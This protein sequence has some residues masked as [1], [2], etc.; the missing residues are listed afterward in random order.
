MKKLRILVL[1]HED[2]VPP[3]SLDGYTDKEIIEWKTEYDVVSTLRDMG[4]EVIPLGVHDDLGSIR[5]TFRDSRPHIA[6]NL[7]EEFHGNSL[8][9]YH[10]ASYM[11]LLRLHYT[12]CNPRGLMLAHDKSLCKKLLAF[13][14]INT[15]RFATFPLGRK[16]RCPKRLRFP[17]IVKSLVEEGSYGLAQASVVNTEEKLLER[18]QYLHE[19]LETPVIAEEYIDG[20]E[21][22][23]AV[24]GNLRLQVLPVLELKFGDLPEGTH[25]FATT[26]V[27]WDWNYQDE[28][29]IEV[30]VA[31]DIPAG[32]MTELTRLGKRIYKVL[33]MSGYARID[34]R[35]T[36]N[37]RLYVL[38]ANANP[39]IGYG[40][41][42]S[43]AAEAAG[44]SYEQLLQKVINLGLAYKSGM[45]R[46]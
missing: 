1:M 34:L 27:K 31:E 29:K 4:H 38:E 10:I 3:D 23:V 11:E 5:R 7:L 28:H 15:P 12:G 33:G 37:N 26:R 2:L 42:L 17:L 9:D 19:K 35:L 18:V 14:R 24:V 39:D 44:I 30:V 32:I 20:R 16:V 40:E 41:E 22:Y 46:P 6:F 43:L 21:L 25:R 13:H 36:E 45:V 8:Y